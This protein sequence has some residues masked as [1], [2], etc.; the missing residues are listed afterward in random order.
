VSQT[1]EPLAQSRM[2][3]SERR[4][5][6]AAMCIWP[7]S[8]MHREEESDDVS[9]GQDTASAAPSRMTRVSQQS[10][11][12]QTDVEDALGGDW[13]RR[14]EAMSPEERMM[15]IKRLRD[16]S[17]EDRD[18]PDEIETP[19][20]I[21]ARI[22]FQKYR[23]LQ[24][25]RQSDW[26]VNESLPLDYARIFKFQNFKR[27][28]RAAVASA[29]EGDVGVDTYVAVVL[30]AV[31]VKFMEVW[32]SR[33]F[34][35]FSGLLAHEQR[36]TVQH[37]TVQRNKEYTEPIK[38]KTRLVVHFG[39]RK[40]VCNPLFSEPCKG[41]RTKFMRYFHPEDKFVTASIF[42]PTM[43][44]PTPVLC[45]MPVTRDEKQQGIDMPLVAYGKAEHPNADL[46]LLKKVTLAGHIY[47]SHK[48]QCIVRFMF[49]NEDDVKWFQPIEL[50]TKLGFRGKIIKSV[51]THGHMKVQFSGI[52]QHHDV[53]CLDLW[54]RVFP[55][56]TTA[57]FSLLAD[58]PQDEVSDSGE[59]AE[60][61]EMDQDET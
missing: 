7:N 8:C 40:L 33:T 12:A 13:L 59:E 23:G 61:D 18:F 5:I 46:L 3:S 45:F 47:K 32:E 28:W 58:E 51:G 6:P 25:F 22:R 19:L 39:F 17:Q 42:G 37:F 56:W 4:P 16:A 48:R 55:K 15:E 31:P 20:H 49:H 54:K 11:A 14:D 24:S 57:T 1:W 60:E 27:T 43:Y 30:R 21:P 36:Y 9:P 35:I 53:V 41:G 44:Q 2:M 52:I 34:L 38:S 50:Y 10:L 26:D 29:G